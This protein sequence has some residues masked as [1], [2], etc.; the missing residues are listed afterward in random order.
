MCSSKLEIRINLR[1]G[2]TYVSICQYVYEFVD[3]HTVSFTSIRIFDSII[4]D[5]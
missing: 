3:R 4:L 1:N 2:I 5:I